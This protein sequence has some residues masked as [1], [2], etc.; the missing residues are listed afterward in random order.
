MKEK[1]RFMDII[2]GRMKI[3]KINRYTVT[4][5][6]LLIVFVDKRVMQPNNLDLNNNQEFNLKNNWTTISPLIQFEIIR[7]NYQ[8]F[9]EQKFQEQEFQKYNE[10]YWYVRLF[11]EMTF[12]HYC[13][14]FLFMY[15][16][17]WFIQ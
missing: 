11:Y 1:Y 12:Q 4:V 6:L 16:G 2:G 3:F 8:K 14:I 10:K 9:S 13:D 17:T 7:H 15:N 5:I